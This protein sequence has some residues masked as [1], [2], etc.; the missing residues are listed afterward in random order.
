MQGKQPLLNTDREK[1]KALDYRH[2]QATNH[3]ECHE[4]HLLQL[5]ID[6]IYGGLTGCETI[7]VFTDQLLKLASPLMQLVSQRLDAL[8]Q[9]CLF[10]V[11]QGNST[12]NAACWLSLQQE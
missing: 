7:K 12:Q 2:I 10:G 11:L 4:S 1:K 3:Q 5:C 6:V 8:P 9:C